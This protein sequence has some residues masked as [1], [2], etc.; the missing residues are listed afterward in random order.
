MIPNDL[1]IDQANELLE[2]A[3][4]TI[5]CVF[6]K[7]RFEIP[8][9][10]KKKSNEKRGVFVSL[11]IN[12]EL[13]GCIGFPEPVMPLYRAVVDATMAAAF[14]DMRFLSLKKEEFVDLKIELSILT[15]PEEIIVDN[16][17]EYPLNVKIGSDGLIIK[18]NMFSG[19]LLPQVAKKHKW[20]SKE[21]LDNTCVKAGLGP[22]CWKEDDC[23]VYKFQA[24][25]FSM[26]KGIMV[27]KKV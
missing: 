19:L 1:S 23:R 9:D 20:N 18:N 25:V 7:K 4:N 12:K 15:K 13:N 16:V 21:F 14:D 5:S 17:S 8:E 3:Q 2:L 11:Y 24:Q 26:E 27:G 22:G 6:E 10:I